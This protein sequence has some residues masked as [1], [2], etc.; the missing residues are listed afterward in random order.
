MMKAW[1]ILCVGPSPNSGI[2][3]QPLV[4]KLPSNIILSTAR[5]PGIQEIRQPSDPFR[6]LTGSTG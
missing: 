2:K 4:E 6:S 5:N 3:A 1:Q